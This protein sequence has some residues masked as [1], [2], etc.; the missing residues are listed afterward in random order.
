[1]NFCSLPRRATF[2][3]NRGWPLV[4]GTTVVA[5]VVF[6][7][8]DTHECTRLLG[9]REQMCMFQVLDNAGKYSLHPSVLQTME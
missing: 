9:E 3:P 1:M 5:N 4:A 2:A 7:E 6:L 8:L